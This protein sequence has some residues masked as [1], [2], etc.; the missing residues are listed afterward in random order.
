MGYPITFPEIEAKKQSRVIVSKPDA[1]GYKG[2]NGFEYTQPNGKNQIKIPL[3]R[4]GKLLEVV[5]GTF[6]V[7]VEFDYPIPDALIG[8]KLIYISQYDLELL[9]TYVDT[10]GNKIFAAQKDVWLRPKPEVLANGSLA[11]KRYPN[12][13]DEIGKLTNQASGDYVQVITPDNTIGWVKAKV[14]TT[15]QADGEAVSKVSTD[16]PSQV[17][18]KIGQKSFSFST[19]QAIIGGV[20]LL[21]GFGALLWVINQLFRK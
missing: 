8:S 3:S 16:T 9:P 10:T 15:T 20:V 13:G 12:I 6:W 17:D 7:K 1:I 21:I 19:Q 14:V 4:T 5:S 18:F 2:L 11:L